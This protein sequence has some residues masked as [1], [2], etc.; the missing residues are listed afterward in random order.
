MSIDFMGYV[1]EKITSNNETFDCWCW[2]AP[3][4]A[5]MNASD[6]RA[7][8]NLANGNAYN[9]IEQMGL[10]LDNTGSIPADEF[11]AAIPR[12]NDTLLAHYA[13][14]LLALANFAKEC[15]ATHVGWG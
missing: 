14:R 7:C 9:V 6:P 11:I 4:E 13:P 15:G 12:L 1:L 8:V 2:P 5:A 3:F 10:D